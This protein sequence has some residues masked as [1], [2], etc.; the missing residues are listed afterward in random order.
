M[1]KTIYLY[2]IFPSELEDKG[3]FE[4]LEYK[5]TAATKLYRS[6]F[7]KPDKTKKDND[8]MF[9]VNKAIQHTQK[10]LDERIT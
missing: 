8:R 9:Y 5:K 3:Y 1:K 6:L 2:G 4:A 7:L 10:L